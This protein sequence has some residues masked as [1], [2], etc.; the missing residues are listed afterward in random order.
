MDINKLEA[1][2]DALSGNAYPVDQWQPNNIGTID[3]QITANGQWYHQQGLI[4]RDKLVTL[5]S[6]I[7]T[8]DSQQYYLVTPAEKLQIVVDDAPFVVVDF[9][10]EQK[11][12]GQTVW[13]IT[14]I[15]DKVPLSETYNVIL[16]GPE[17]RPYIKLWRGLEALIDRTTYYQ[18]ID[19]AREHQ[20][21][22]ETTMM[23]SSQQQQFCLGRF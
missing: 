23:I 6:K 5:F 16:K 2:L 10:I 13:L 8:K 18:L 19:C 12:D 22:G 3:I 4:K 11:G 21:D 20:N 14:N 7:L 15:G 1:A 17:Q 9:D